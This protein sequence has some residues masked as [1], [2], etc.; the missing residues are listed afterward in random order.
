MDGC[1]AAPELTRSE[2]RL[3]PLLATQLSLLEV[4]RLLERPRDEVQAEA[5]SIYRK[6]GL[7]PNRNR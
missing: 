5:A 6:L 3:L 4:S 2:E 7:S 1:R